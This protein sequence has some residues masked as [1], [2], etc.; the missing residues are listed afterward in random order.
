M[1]TT[2][3][4]DPGFIETAVDFIRTYADRCHHGKEEDILFRD[5]EKK[6]MSEEHKEIM[7]ELVEEHRWGRKTTRE[8][9]EAKEKYQQGDMEALSTIVDRMSFL[10][11]FYPKHIEKEDRHFF[12]PV[13]SYFTEEEKGAMLKEEYEFDRQFIHERYKDVVEEAEDR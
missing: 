2:G 9:L 11:N 3:K 13:M 12:I 6:A 1:E 4:A 10:V 5:L 7:D 8:L